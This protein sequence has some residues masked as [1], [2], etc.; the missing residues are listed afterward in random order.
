MSRVQPIL[1]IMGLLI[2]SLSLL[3]LLCGL[4]DA[5][6]G[7]PDSAN[8]FFTCTFM[9][10]FLGGLLTLTCSVNFNTF[11]LKQTFIL[12][13]LCWVVLSLGAACPFY[14]L[15][16]HSFIDCFFE[17]MSG[18]TTTGATV[19]DNL[20]QL[21]PS[22]LLWRSILQW[23]GGIGIIVIA[24]SIFPVLHV[25]GMQI[26]RSESSD[27]SEKIMPRIGQI[28]NSIALVY[29]GLTFL[30][31]AALCVAGMPFFD[32][33]CHSMTCVATGGF[34]T[35]D[36]SIGFFHSDWIKI[37]VTIFMILG[38]VPFVLFIS[39]LTHGPLFLWRNTQVIWFMGIL[40]LGVL[41]VSLYGIIIDVPLIDSV[42]NTVSVFTGTGYMTADYANWGAF[43]TASF[44]VMM[45][46]GGCTGS[47]T[48][49]IKIFRIVV[50]LKSLRTQFKCLLYPNGVFLTY[51]SDRVISPRNFLSIYAFF[52]LFLLTFLGSSLLLAFL[53]YDVMTSFS[54]AASAL[55]NV[56]PGLGPIIGP[57]KNFA[58]LSE[59]TKL[60]LSF[61]MLVGRLEILTVF[62]LFTPSF[63]RF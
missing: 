61:L 62:I 30:C 46:I 45:F 10:L 43:V 49:G 48:G 8:I 2:G 4:V 47:A 50:I 57:T 44:L 36:T 25:G 19:L 51:Y 34:S 33:V 7:L 3:M 16:D 37:I 6:Y 55:C 23:V 35:H 38:G 52:L 28:A 42:F 56:G 59:T 9:G 17:S 40:L 21:P 60:F 27:T 24:M 32:S 29:V 1:Y 53:G 14:W 26:F 18:L 5:Y 31:L 15:L 22:L 20:H 54:G 58:T 12:T 63:W 39:C 11:T 13:T 41:M